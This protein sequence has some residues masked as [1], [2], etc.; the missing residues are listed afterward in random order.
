MIRPLPVTA[1]WLGQIS[2]QDAFELQILIKEQILAGKSGSQLL[3]LEHPPVITLGASFHEQNLLLTPDAYAARGITLAKTDRG[4]D[5]TYH[6]PGQL[7]AY[8]IFDLRALKQDLHWYIRQ[9]EQAFVVAC[10]ELGVAARADSRH[11][12]IWCEEAIIGSIGVK[13]SKW[14]TLHGVALNCSNDLA[15]FQLIHPCGMAGQAITS[16]S[17]ELGEPVTPIAAINAVKLGFEEAF[18]ILCRMEHWE[19]N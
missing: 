11:S 6:G 1:R 13:V 14:I 3:L 18:C 16:L 8:P 7:V 2:Y 4:G 15:P 5:V 9:L 17:Q 19:R 10:R 12:G